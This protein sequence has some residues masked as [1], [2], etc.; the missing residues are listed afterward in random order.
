M[1]GGTPLA[2]AQHVYTKHSN[3]IWKNVWHT[4]RAKNPYMRRADCVHDS[5]L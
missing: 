1:Q 5:Q 3:R 4:S 2:C